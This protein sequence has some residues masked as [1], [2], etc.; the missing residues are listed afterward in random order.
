MIEGRDDTG[1]S[2]LILT[3]M[4]IGQLYQDQVVTDVVLIG[5]YWW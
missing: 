4:L 1:I 2:H 3:L 5:D